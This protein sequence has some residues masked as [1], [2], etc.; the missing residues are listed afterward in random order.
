VEV[1]E[2]GQ[3][4]TFSGRVIDA[5]DH[6]PLDSWA[7]EP[8]PKVKPKERAARERPVLSG[9]R[10]LEAA[11]QRERDY[12]RDRLERERI[13]NAVDNIHGE[14]SSP[15][16]ALVSARHQH[17]S[18]TGSPMNSGAMVLHDSVSTPPGSGG[19]NRLQKRNQRPMSTY[20]SPNRSSPHIPMPD[21]DVLRERENPAGYGS[22]GASSRHSVAAPPIP[23][24]IPLENQYPPSEDMTALSLELQSIDI[25]PGSGGRQRGTNR[26][27]YGGY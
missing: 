12:R 14:S 2:K 25:G 16:T 4:V 17:S 27:R 15:S 8:E 24:K 5:S 6:L 10:D 20:D 1:N 22:Y 21:T 23:A 7:P 13:R 18:S 9:A 3:V 11:K 26:R 19:R